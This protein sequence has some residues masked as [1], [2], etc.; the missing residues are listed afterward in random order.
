MDHMQVS[1]SPVRLSVPVRGEVW[2]LTS[3]VHLAHVVPVSSSTEAEGKHVV[4]KKHKAGF[5]TCLQ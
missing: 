3:H 1:H 2:L 4:S 5:S